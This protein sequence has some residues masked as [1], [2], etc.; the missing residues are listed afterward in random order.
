MRNQIH[1][2]LKK[3]LANYSIKHKTNVNQ[4]KFILKKE[5]CQKNCFQLPFND[6]TSL[7]CPNTCKVSKELI[8]MGCKYSYIWY[9]QYQ[10]FFFAS[11]PKIEYSKKCCPTK[12]IRAV[13]KVSPKLYDP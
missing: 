3:T 5:D 1:S 10:L 7:F 4:S 9:N 6:S 13:R 11:S 8:C 12:Q 2:S